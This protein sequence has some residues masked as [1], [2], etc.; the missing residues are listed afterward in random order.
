MTVRYVGTFLDDPLQVPV[1]LLDYLAGG[2][3]RTRGLPQPLAGSRLR[4]IP[5]SGVPGA[6]NP[7]VLSLMQ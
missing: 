1:E 7:L 6:G 4:G 2:R 5:P 3:D